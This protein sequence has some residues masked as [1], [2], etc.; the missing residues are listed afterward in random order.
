MNTAYAPGH[1]QKW[2]LPSV[3][4][5]KEAKRIRAE[6]AYRA[7]CHLVNSRDGYRCRVC[8]CS[9]VMH[10]HHVIYRSRGGRDTVDNLCLL[11]ASCHDEEH[12]K[13][14]LAIEGNAE[15]GLS[16]WR[17]SEAQQW[18]LWRQETAVRVYV[19]AP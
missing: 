6:A 4:E 18:F 12:V 5:S 10:H 3:R 16:L 11:C 8:N 13:R 17:R 2:N 19:G 1:F 14:T 15:T 7:A 9:G